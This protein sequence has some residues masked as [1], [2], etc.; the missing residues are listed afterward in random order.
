MEEAVEAARGRA[1]RLLQTLRGDV[2]APAHY[3]AFNVWLCRL[4][5]LLPRPGQPLWATVQPLVWSCLLLHLMC[6]LVDIALNIADVQQLGK[7]LPIS[8]LV[9]G[10][11][12]RL[13]YF[14]MRRDAYWRLVSKVGESFHRGAPGRMRRWLRRSRGFTL[15]YF[16]YGTI[17]CLFWLGHPLL[18]QQTTHTM[19]TS[20]NSTNRSRMSETAEFPSG[21][22]YPFDVRERRVYGAVYGFQCLALYFAAM[23]IMVTDIMFITL[24]LLACGQFEELGDK[25]RHCWEI[26]TTRALSR[27]GTTPERELQKVLAHC[28]RYHDMLLGIVGDIE[29]LHWTSMLVNFVLQLIILSFLAFEATASAD[30]TNP[31]KGTN[32]LMYLVMAIFQLFLLCSCGDR[33]MEAEEMVARAAYESQWFDAPQGAKRSL[34]IIVMRARLP[35]RV[36]VGKVVGLNLVT[37]SETLSRAFSYFTV[38]RQIRTSN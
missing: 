36:T 27:A 4:V 5:G 8:S 29:D 18:L 19:F 7:N 24:M 17:V 30:L 25:L 38:L 23:L 11:W 21:A 13:S 14:T 9:G 31:L 20:S 12:Y 26:A 37:F 34:S 1:P 3:L 28:V 32:L 22:W 2:A 15:A 35:Q 16:V 10:S 6:E 33:L